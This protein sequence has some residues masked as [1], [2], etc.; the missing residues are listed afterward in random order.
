MVWF[1]PGHNIPANPDATCVRMWNRWPT[2]ARKPAVQEP[3]P[4]PMTSGPRKQHV[5]QRGRS[6]GQL[7]GRPTY[8]SADQAHGPHRLNFD[9][10]R[11]PVACLGRF[12]RDQLQMAPPLAVAPS[13]KYRGGRGEMKRT[14][15]TTHPTQ[16]TFLPWSLRPSS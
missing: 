14:P 8:W 13:Y 9:T 12:A 4:V 7:P 16:L 3:I 15:H 2:R 5:D 1:Y 11:F 10:W 6:A